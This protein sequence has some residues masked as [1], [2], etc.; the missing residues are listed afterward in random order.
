MDYLNSLADSFLGESPETSFPTEEH[1]SPALSVPLARAR[2]WLHGRLPRDAFESD[3][4]LQVEE[5]WR[6]QVELEKAL[7]KVEDH[8]EEE[9]LEESAD[10]CQQLALALEDL[11][12]F[13]TEHDLEKHKAILVPIFDR[14]MQLQGQLAQRAREQQSPAPPSTEPAFNSG[15]REVSPD[16][17]Q[18]VQW[19]GQPQHREQASNHLEGMLSRA[20]QARQFLR[21]HPEPLQQAA[22]QIVRAM[23]DLLSS[24]DSGEEIALRLEQLVLDHEEFTRVLHRYHQG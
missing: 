21:Q 23:E 24:L 13:Q 7:E 20:R 8:D 1:P 11:A 12:A 17:Y 4:G 18:L 16:I 19:L 3:L 6:C 15:S 2:S 14:L 5:F 22:A 9:W 10:L